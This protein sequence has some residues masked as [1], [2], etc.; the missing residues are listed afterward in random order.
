MRW[1]VVKERKNGK[2]VTNLE[3]YVKIMNG[4]KL[5]NLKLE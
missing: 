3:E 4:R 5:A 2:E 1:K